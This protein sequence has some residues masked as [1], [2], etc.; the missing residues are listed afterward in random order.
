MKL[1]KLIPDSMKACS[2]GWVEKD[3]SKTR[4]NI[5]PSHEY[6]NKYHR[7]G[8]EESYRHISKSLP[9]Q[10]RNEGKDVSMSNTIEFL[11]SEEVFVKIARYTSQVLVKRR[12]E[13]VNCYE[14]RQFFAHKLLRSRFDVSTEKA[15]SDFMEPLAVKHG[16]TLM[17]VARFNNILTSVRG[18]DVNSRAGDSGDSSWKQRKNLLRSLEEIEKAMFNRSASFLFNTKNGVL[19]VDD[20]LVGSRASDVE[21]KAHSQRKTGVDGPVSDAMADSMIC[22]LLGMRL[23]VTGESQRDNVR[24]L[25]KTAPK[26]TDSTDRPKFSTDRGLS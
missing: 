6:T 11:V 2:T 5:I 23:R 14:L 3:L 16:F 4:F 19:V 10:L 17:P 21:S 15:W 8:L 18:Y 22:L 26:S 25:L 9:R 7:D 24:E 20:E 1:S 12:L 13:P